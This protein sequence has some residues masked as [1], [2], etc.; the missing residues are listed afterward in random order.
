LPAS[1]AL[2]TWAPAARRDADNIWDYYALNASPDIASAMIYK[3]ER[4]ADRVAAHPFY[5]RSRDNF[6]RGS[7]SILVHPYVLFY[8]LAED[9]IEV[10][11]V[12]HQR[13]D[14]TTILRDEG[15]ARPA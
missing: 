12:L 11:R 4:A 13:R 14:L 10:I 1:K 9:G 15:R 7:R 8:R 3:I 2:A 6:L 5:G